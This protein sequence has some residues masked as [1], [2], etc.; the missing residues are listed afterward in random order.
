MH[1]LPLLP[2]MKDT[3]SQ[4]LSLVSVVLIP[5]IPNDILRDIMLVLAPLFFAA[6]LVHHNMP[7]RR[8]EILGASATNLKTLF[9]TAADECSRDPR[10][11]H[12]TGWELDEINYTLSTLR[13]R[14]I[15]MK[16]VSWTECPYHLIAIMRAIDGCRRDMEELEASILLALE[17]ARQQ[18]LTEDIDHRRATLASAFPAALWQQSSTQRRPWTAQLPV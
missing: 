1:T 3:A 11:V 9:N 12:E 2:S 13:T 16:Y 4:L 5:F 7:R 8:V 18:R 17:R 14:T 10:F 15:S 6:C